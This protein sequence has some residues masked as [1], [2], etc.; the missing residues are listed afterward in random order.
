MPLPDPA[1]PILY[2]HGAGQQFEAEFLKR[3]LDSILIG[4]LGAIETRLA[5]F[6]DVRH[7]PKPPPPQFEMV[8]RRPESARAAAGPMTLSQPPAPGAGARAIRVETMADAIAALAPEQAKPEYVLGT[9]SDL[10]VA[11]AESADIPDTARPDA[12]RLA[13]RLIRRASAPI[14]IES[15]NVPDFAF[16]LILKG[17]AEDVLEYFWNDDIRDKMRA[18]VRASLQRRKLPFVLIAHSLGSIIAF[19]MLS[20]LGKKVPDVQ[21]V[22]A[23]SPLG[24]EDVQIRLVG[25]SK[26]PVT[27]PPSV[28]SWHNFAASRDPVALSKVLNGDFA[29]IKISDHGVNLPGVAPM[30]HALDGYLALARLKAV[31]IRP[32]P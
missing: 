4:R 14:V 22:T 8:V 20:E 3:T 18:P 10:A 19:D 9:P 2:V 27:T 30:E 31:A 13:E 5:Y 23:G 28:R 15:V 17:F 6:A 7:T 1:M 29:G 16:R 26:A 25:G 21:L 11:A 24:I 12:T 32:R